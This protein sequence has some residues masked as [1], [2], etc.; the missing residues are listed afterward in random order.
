VV[1]SA[2]GRAFTGSRSF[3]EE[4]EVTRAGWCVSILYYVGYRANLLTSIGNEQ[5]LVLPK[6]VMALIASLCD[7]S[8]YALARRVYGSDTAPTAV[9]ISLIC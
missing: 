5:L 3:L 8:T 7:T 2:F 1:G 9:K 4:W 6:L